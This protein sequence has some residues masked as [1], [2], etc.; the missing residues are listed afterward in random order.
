VAGRE[1][2][3]KPAPAVNFTAVLTTLIANGRGGKSRKDF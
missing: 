3:R 2:L 1:W